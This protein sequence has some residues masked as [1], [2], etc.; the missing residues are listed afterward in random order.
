MRGN[1]MTTLLTINL[2]DKTAEKETIT[3]LQQQYLGGLGINSSLALELIPPGC[4]PLDE[5]NV[6]LVGAGSLVGTGLPTACRTDISSKS[7]LSGRFGSAN[8]GGSWGVKLIQAGI[9]HLCIAGKAER[10]TILYLD[11]EKIFFEEASY[12][13]GEDTWFT[14]DWIR[15]NKG[16]DYQVA[17]IGPAGENGVAFA[18]IQ[19][20]YY[21]AWA[22]TGM[23][24][25]MGSKNLKA[26]AVRG[27]GKAAVA[28]PQEL[29]KIKEEALQKIKGDN[30]F[31]WTRKYGSMVVSTPFNTLGALPG[32]N[33]TTGS[34]PGWE[35]TRGRKHFLETYKVKKLACHSCPI[36][37]AHW[38]RVNEGPYEGFA[39]RGP[40]VT[41]VLEF[42]ARLDISSLPEIFKCV[43]L[44]NR[45]GLD[46]ISTAAAIAFLIECAE[47][48][49][50]SVNEIG[51][52]PAW[53]NYRD[54]SRLIGLI[55]HREGI[56]QFLSLGVRAASQNVPGSEDFA[57]HIKGVEISTRDPRAKPDTWALGYLTNTRGGDHLRSRSPVELLSAGLLD[58]RNEELGVIPEQI[59]KLDMPA[60]LK[61]KIF[62]NPPAKVSIPL[63]IGYA[64]DLITIM[65]ST[66]LCIRPPVLRTL[67]PDFFARA[68][69]A[70]TGSTFTAEGVLEAAGKIWHLQHRFNRREGE[71][72][73][74]YVFSPR[75]YR[76]PLPGGPNQEEYPP[77]SRKHVQQVIKEYFAA[78]GILLPESGE[79]D[80]L[81]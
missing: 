50:L 43:E 28:H 59:E 40:E 17:C 58:H 18:S 49:L 67:G 73:R 26:I 74:E 21:G 19:N 46:V 6:L 29:K 76:E 15:K 31:I 78:R 22:R 64:E 34:L 62:G 63:M 32:R 8:S 68:L 80:S 52:R 47:K 13:W 2:T 65:N 48:E 55:A 10:P 12:L 3:E 30:S 24:A 53:G 9:H 71:S 70:A 1:K 36:A 54:I 25:V 69:N 33:Y 75:F 60:K 38:S 42:G 44:C 77:L 7:P 79:E 27:N 61:E 20:N 4:P 37:C 45:Y 66:G 41:N 51:F 5:R 39:A 16:R 72:Y 57:H 81:V 11:G 23:G 14:V 35:E 56:G